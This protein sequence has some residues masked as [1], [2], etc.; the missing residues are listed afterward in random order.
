MITYYY[1][2]PRSKWLLMGDVWFR[3]PSSNH[4]PIQRLVAAVHLNFNSYVD[5]KNIIITS[6]YFSDTTVSHWKS[7]KMQVFILYNWHGW[8]IWLTPVS[9]ID[10]LF[11]KVEPKKNQIMYLVFA[12]KLQTSEALVDDKCWMNICH[13]LYLPPPTLKNKVLLLSL[14]YCKNKVNS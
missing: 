1:L 11:I 4:R 3:F 14:L 7:W 8:N 2:G 5:Q 12:W 9:N 10:C 13:D 6:D